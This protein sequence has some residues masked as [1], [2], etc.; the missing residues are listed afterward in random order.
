MHTLLHLT[1]EDS[2][3]RRFVEAGELQDVCGIDPV[4]ASA[5]H[6]MVASDFELVNRDIAVCGRVDI[7]FSLVHREK[8]VRF[9]R[10][11]SGGLPGCRWYRKGCRKEV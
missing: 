1:L 7:A 10:F 3:A 11:V 6:D 8:C 4:I 5:A 2:G 9:M